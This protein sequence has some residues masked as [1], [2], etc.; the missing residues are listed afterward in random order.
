MGLSFKTA[1]KVSAVF[2]VLLM[3]GSFCLATSTTTTLVIS[4]S[5]PPYYYN[6]QVTLTATVSGSPNVGT[7]NFYEVAGSDSGGAPDILLNGLSNPNGFTPSNGVVT[8]TTEFM[9]GSHE[10]Y[11]VYTGSGSFGSSTS[12]NHAITV[13]SPLKVPDSEVYLGIRTDTP[14]EESTT[15]TLENQITSDLGL[16]ATYRFPFHIQYKQWTVIAN[17]VNAKGTWYPDSDF[18]GDINYGRIPVLSWS[19]DGTN[20]YSD[21]EIVSGVDDANIS[22]TAIALSQYPGPVLFRW[23]WEFNLYGFHTI[24]EAPLSP[25]QSNTAA[26]SSG[27]M[28]EF[29]KAWQ[30]IYTLFQ[31]NGATN[32]VFLW[33]PGR[34]DNDTLSYRNPSG[35][36]PGNEFVDWIGSD[37]YQFET[38]P[39]GV[40][41][42]TQFT[43][44]FGLGST[45]VT[46]YNDYTASK[47]D[48]KPLI[49]GENGSLNTSE[50][51]GE[52]QPTYFSGMKTDWANG[53]YPQIK[54]YNYYDNC[55]NPGQTR[56]PTFD[57]AGLTAYE[58][59][60]VSNTDFSATSAQ[61]VVITSP[62]AYG[63]GGSITPGGAAIQI[64]VTVADRPGGSY[65]GTV[66]MT[67]TGLVRGMATPTWSNNGFTVSAGNPVTTTLTLQALSNASPN[68]DNVVI[69]ARANGGDL[70]GS[71]VYPLT[72]GTGF[73]FTLTLSSSSGS[74]VAGSGTQASTVIT[75]AP[76]P[77]TGYT[78]TVNLTAT[79]L[80]GQ[81]GSGTGVTPSFSSSSISGGSGNS[82]LTLNSGSNTLLASYPVTITGT[83]SRNPEWNLSV[84]Y[85][86]TVNATSGGG[87][88]GGEC[89]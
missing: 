46:F 73:P 28:T 57:T 79:N 40:D 49:V 86:L 53:D 66:N 81:A 50:G 19:C 6:T 63:T 33:N 62:A 16:S 39:C 30:H 22:T 2:V 77:G 80:G 24:C 52:L 38:D 44:D 85:N 89:P 4:P 59:D 35:F 47:Y 69:T 74:E 48:D 42:P 12:S 25:P 7:I 71:V 83:D 51:Y 11:A 61:D 64:P 56:N 5:S 84:T 27:D 87:G 18:I 75:V 68:L 67:V 23:N 54:A 20:T 3:S 31:Q 45:C 82:T 88:G 72:I 58:D 9:G 32:V 17:E 43:D 65:S 1:V 76:A 55:S 60:L 21:S 36:Y 14:D 34:Y 78:G 13:N 15:E 70:P 41:S 10:V 29:V 26:Y 37:S 8:W